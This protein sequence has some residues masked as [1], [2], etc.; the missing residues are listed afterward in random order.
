M[1]IV[2]AGRNVTPTEEEENKKKTRNR[3][4][5]YKEESRLSAG[6]DRKWLSAP[7]A[8]LFICIL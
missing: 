5:K 7:F 1:N 2:N 4:Q 8:D 6:Q 3:S